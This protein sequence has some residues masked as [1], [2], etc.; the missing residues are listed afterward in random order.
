[1]LRRINARFSSHCRKCR[2]QI[3][4]G[5]PVYWGKGIGT[6]CLDCGGKESLPKSEDAPKTSAPKTDAPKVEL[7]TGYSDTNSEYFTMDW[8]EFKAILKSVVFDGTE[9]KLNTTHNADYI[10]R[11][12]TATGS[13]EGFT[14]NQVKEWLKDGYQ[15]DALKGLGDNVKPIREKRKFRFVEEGDEFHYDLAYA[16]EDRYMSEMTPREK[17]PGAAIEA[18]IMFSSATDA[19]VISAYSVWLCKMAYS[20]E[21]AGVDCQITL[22]FPSKGMV[23][24]SRTDSKIWHNIVRVKRE[25][26]LSD[27]LSWSAM[28]S[29]AALRSFG[30][31]LGTLHADSKNQRVAY[32]FGYGM[33]GIR[34]DWKVAWDSKRRVIVVEN[35]YHGGA[36]H[37]F[38]EERMTA[39]FKAVLGQM[40]QA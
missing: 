39:Q 36:T 12:L 34:N 24:G 21:S 1:M 18:G 3:Y 2:R 11:K 37:S 10:T 33:L 7:P 20:L 8:M 28:L 35:P 30:F 4:K 27:F 6:F 38:P 9:L 32:N 25:M 22:D 14:P 26:D 15:P 17:I 40:T 19:K 31:C 16:G 13:W 5:S 29:P 23:S